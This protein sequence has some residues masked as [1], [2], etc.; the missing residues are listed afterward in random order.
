LG[1]FIEFSSS[2]EKDDNGSSILDLAYFFDYSLMILGL[3]D[4]VVIF[5]A[6]FV[7]AKG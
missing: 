4:D 7:Y 5:G 2:L 1:E 3:L 6:A